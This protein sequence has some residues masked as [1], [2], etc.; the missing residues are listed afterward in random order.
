MNGAIT[1][2]PEE[3]TTYTVT[4]TDANGCASEAQV[5]VEVIDVRCGNGRNNKVQLCHR[6]R[7]ICVSANSV[8]AHLRHG[9]TLG[10]CGGGTPTD[11]V[12]VSTY[13]NPF[14][15]KIIAK[16]KTT[17]KAKVTFRLYNQNGRTVKRTQATVNKKEKKIWLNVSGLARGFYYLETTINGEKYRSE[18]LVKQ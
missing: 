16:V 13:P 2:C 9:D 11:A 14:T 6:G 8:A 12:N 10:S 18:Q 7:T 15:N 5:T 4:V 17:Q 3:T 1:V